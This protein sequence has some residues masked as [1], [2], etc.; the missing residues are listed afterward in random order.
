[1]IP[2]FYVNQMVSTFTA[3]TCQSGASAEDHGHIMRNRARIQDPLLWRLLP[4]ALRTHLQT[5]RAE[6]MREDALITAWETSPH[7]LR[8]IGVVLSQADDLPDHLVAAPDRV[9]QHV[10]RIS[11]DQV[12]EA[13]VQFPPQNAK[14][15]PDEQT[16]IRLPAL[17]QPARGQHPTGFATA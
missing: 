4:R 5:R 7:L 11:P 1:M 14:A 16:T 12:I 13:Q 6:R 2:S 9:I 3:D 8:D 10:A 17:A 15:A